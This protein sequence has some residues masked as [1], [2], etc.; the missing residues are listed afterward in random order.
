MQL[1]TIEKK[2]R[3]LLIR[4]AQGKKQ[5][6]FPRLI[7][8]KE[9]WEN[10]SEE[11]WGR[12]RKNRIVDIITKISAFDID[13]GLPPLNE[14]VVVKKT[15][16]PGEEWSG[17]KSYIK[18]RSGKTSPYRSHIEAQQA[19]WEYWSSEV[20]ATNTEGKV[21]EGVAQDKTVVFRKRN[22]TLVAERKKR[23]KNTCQACG[24]KMRAHGKYIIDV[25]HKYPLSA[26]EGARVTSVKDLVCLC[27]NCHRIAHTKKFPLSPEEISRVIERGS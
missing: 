23:D 18:K 11:K 12:G 27:P 25:H 6:I 14:L 24:Y 20:N 4:V 1:N 19:C 13:N 21:E 22:Q 5:T 26:S 10:I 2:T 9:L 3:T 15:G 8:Y 17:I 7:T 16:L